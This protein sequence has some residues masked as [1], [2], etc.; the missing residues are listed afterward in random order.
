MDASTNSR[1]DG[2]LRAANNRYLIGEIEINPPERIPG[3]TR[4]IRIPG[5]RRSQEM[6]KDVALEVA[7]GL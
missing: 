7:A 1:S 2:R 3:E 6:L 5:G 4:G